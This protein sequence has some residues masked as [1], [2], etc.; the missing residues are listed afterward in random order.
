MRRERARQASPPPARDPQPT[1][2]QT[3][4]AASQR[5]GV[6]EEEL[7][8]RRAQEEADA[9]LARRLQV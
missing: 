2:L 7:R 8:R 3:G 9:E 4:S 1:R 5:S 6:S